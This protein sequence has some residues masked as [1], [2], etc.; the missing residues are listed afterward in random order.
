M[1]TPLLSSPRAAVRGLLGAAALSAGCATTGLEGAG[2]PA[3]AP[4]SA[5]A[6]AQAARADPRQALIRQGEEA[7]AQ[8][9]DPAQL[10]R[11]LAAWRDALALGDSPELRLRLARAEHFAGQGLAGASRKEHF[12]RGADQA[13]RAARL[14]TAKELDDPCRGDSAAKLAAPALYWLAENLDAYSREVGLLA[15]AKERRQAMC[16][17]RQVAEAEPGYFHAGPLRLL[18]RLLAQAPTNLGGDAKASRAA[19]ERAVAISPEFLANRVDLAATVAVKLQDVASF[20]AALSQ[21]L[22]AS[23]GQSPEIAPENSLAKRRAERLKGEQG[24]LFR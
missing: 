13:R 22:E 23:A 15:S 17:A 20:E 3:Q 5:P 8:R 19:F 12:E 1:K 10:E 11:A 4:S 18:G 9:S 6:V 24:A 14:L 7:F 2:P 21:V 16:L